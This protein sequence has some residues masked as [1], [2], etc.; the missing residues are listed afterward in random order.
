MWKIEKD[1]NATLA[2]MDY[3]TRAIANMSIAYGSPK[4]EGFITQSFRRWI[5]YPYPKRDIKY[6]RTFTF[7][8]VR[9]WNISRSQNVACERNQMNGLLLNIS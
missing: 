2:T 9:I 6:S 4:K 7:A 3:P 1:Q 8:D 5:C